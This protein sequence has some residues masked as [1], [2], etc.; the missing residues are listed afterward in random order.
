MS[1]NSTCLSYH[2]PTYLPTCLPTYLSS[3][4]PSIRPSIRPPSIYPYLYLSTIQPLSLPPTVPHPIAPCPCHREDAP[5]PPGLPPPCSLKSLEVSAH[6]L[7][8]EADQA[9]LCCVCVGG[10]GPA[11]ACCLVGGSVS[12]SSQGSGL[13]EMLVFLW[14]LPPLQLLPPYFAL[15]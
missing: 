14:G 11:G 12:G 4:H 6:L 8:R 3:I 7:P 9:V 15:Q 2:L 1:M 5:P 10:L 13:A